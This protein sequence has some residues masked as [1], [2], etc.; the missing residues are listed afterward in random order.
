MPILLLALNTSE[1]LKST[2]VDI[3]GKVYN[4]DILYDT[5]DAKI[6]V[7]HDFISENECEILEKNGRNRLTKMILFM[8][9]TPEFWK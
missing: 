3:R 5:P 7:M 6:W 2:K 1:P 4:T 9:Y 8:I